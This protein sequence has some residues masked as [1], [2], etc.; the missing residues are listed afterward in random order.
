[1]SRVWLIMQVQVLLL[2]PRPS[3]SVAERQHCQ[4]FS[5]K[6]WCIA[7]G[8]LSLP[9]FKKTDLIFHTIIIIIIINLYFRL[10]VRTQH[11]FTNIYSTIGNYM[12]TTNYTGTLPAYFQTFDTRGDTEL[13]IHCMIV[14]L[15]DWIRP[16][17][18]NID[19]LKSYPNDNILHISP[20]IFF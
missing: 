18:A 7:A 9:H 11:T 14:L 8:V 15:L 6:R 13:T 16:R 20:S 4:C 1:M 5:L 2:R 19:F 12:R 3:A 10:A 17:K